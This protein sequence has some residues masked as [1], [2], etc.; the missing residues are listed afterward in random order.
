M[1]ER[2]KEDKEKTVSH[3]LKEVKIYKERKPRVSA[4]ERD[5]LEEILKKKIIESG[6][7]KVNSVITIEILRRG[8]QTWHLNSLTLLPS[9]VGI[10]ISLNLSVL[11][12]LLTNRICQY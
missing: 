1:N 8:F 12:D 3:V 6:N 2:L 11:Y 5:H 7:L 9:M 10:Y 4:K